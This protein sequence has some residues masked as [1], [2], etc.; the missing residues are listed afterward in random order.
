MRTPKRLASVLAVLILVAGHARAG[1]TTD[2]PT[3]GF[4]ALRSGDNPAETALGPATVAALAPAW[5]FDAA[6]YD[7]AMDSALQT[8]F[9]NPGGQPVVA[10]GVPVG[11]VPTDLVLI[12]DGNG[13]VTAL[14]ANSPSPQGSVVWHVPLGTRLTASGCTGGATTAGIRAALAIDRTANGGNGAVYVGENG[15]VHALDLATGAEL[16]GWPVVLPRP[17]PATTDGYMRDGPNVIGG[18]L[19]VGTSSYCDLNPYYG[20]VVRIDTATATLNGVWFTLSGSALPPAARG[21][22]IWGAGGVSIDPTAASG[23]VY[24]AT[25]NA[26]SGPAQQGYAENIV[27]L[28]PDLTQVA[29]A[30]TPALPPG[31]H[32]Y[33]ATPAVFQ[34]AGCPT[35]LLAAAN[36]SGLLVLESVA[37]DGSL[38]VAQSLPMTGAGGSFAGTAAWDAAD[39]LLLVTTSVNGPAPYQ[40]GLSAFRVAAGCAPPALVL[41]WQTTTDQTGGK[42][43]ADKAPVSSPVV[44]N[45]LAWF[46]VGGAP[47]RLFAV[48]TSGSSAGK[49]VWQSGDLG[50]AVMMTP[51]VVNGRVFVSLGGGNAPGVVAFALPGG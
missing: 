12:G 26:R 7:V 19:Y 14:D 10:H 20:R 39:Q 50:C 31:D 11:G 22:G 2:W 32:D 13:V 27:D 17:E 3:Y 1:G 49:I 33:G 5:T 29:G 42:L 34:P 36:K 38:A 40:R 51:T 16:A 30:A 35:K 47:A 6:A 43:G 45:G 46:A 4:D 41:A 23:G 25:G 9:A 8:W 28:S 24:L 44:A 18:E 21:G 15:R 48:A 37:A